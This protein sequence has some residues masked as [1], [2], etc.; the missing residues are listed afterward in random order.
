MMKLITLGS[1]VVLL[2]AC[3]SQEL[4]E[5]GYSSAQNVKMQQCEKEQVEGCKREKYESYQIQKEIIRIRR[6]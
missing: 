4:K 6:L 3:T 2:S 5:A 1:I